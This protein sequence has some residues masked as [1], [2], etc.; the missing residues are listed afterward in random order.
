[1][2][3]ARAGRLRRA[4]R[5]GGPPARGFTLFEVLTALAILA[6][7]FVGIFAVF[8]VASDVAQNARTQGAARE[9]A[10][11]VR[12]LLARDLDGVFHPSLTERAGRTGLR[13][14]VPSPSGGDAVTSDGDRVVL[15]M[16]TLSRLDFDRDEPV[17]GLTRVRWLLRPR[18]DGETAF[19]LVRAE[20]DDPHLL[21]A[22]LADVPW[23]ETLVARDV[24]AFS[25]SALDERRAGR[26]SWDSL[27]R[28]QQGSPALPRMLVVAYK[29]VRDPD[30]RSPVTDE[31]PAG[32]FTARLALPFRALT[33]QGVK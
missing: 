19:D 10:R 3:A 32:S 22:S 29:P 16:I 27:S 9:T 6:G 25:V 17:A 12:T 18:D 24:A 31:G 28:E 33:A 20:L 2:K 15:D 4:A 1:V 26:E 13:F 5:G 11:V 23:R 30:D 7:A 8:R 14:L 21:P